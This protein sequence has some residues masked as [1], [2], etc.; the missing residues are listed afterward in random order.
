M[1]QTNISYKQ[2]LLETPFH[3]KT[4]E[5]CYTHD[6]HRWSGYKIAKQYTSA[7]LEYTAIR[8]TA[9]VID[10]TP[11]HKYSVQ[12]KDAKKFINKLITRNVD[13]IQPKQV[14]YALWCNEDGF[15]VDDGT[16]F[17]FDENNFRIC[18]G[19]RNLNW[20]ED[21]AIGFDVIIEDISHSI[22]ALAFQGPL[23][24]KI[25]HML[26]AK[27]IE[28]LKPFCFDQFTINNQE[29]TI[30]RTGFS[31]D[32]GYELWCE[33]SQAHNVWDA[34]FSFNK[35][36]KILAAGLDALEMVRVEAGFI[37]VNADLIAAEHALRPNRMRTPYELGLAWMVNLDKE[38]FSGKE[39]L[40]KQKNKG[41]EK[42]LIGLDVQGDKPAVG[43]VLY[44]ESK[45]KD[46]GIVTAAMW[47]PSLK[48]NIAMGYVD[49]EFMKLGSKVL[50]EIYHPE[51]LEYRKIWA[52]CK[53]VK[54]Q[55]I[56]LE[57]RNA[58]PALI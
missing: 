4:Q 16:I 10:I 15:V 31:G 12:G 11:M 54:K 14:V 29:I 9:G 19:E 44:N 26:N 38:F 6:W 39:A 51:E 34:L 1:S 52:Q 7:E 49:K 28:N 8:N 17:C 46:I 48:S 37:V 24:C 42:K 47:S 2:P 5:R 18:S 58:V 57:R 25:L 21:T 41:V 13:N 36:Y 53:V 20:F 33:P 45:N 40:I 50:A 56:T 55:F 27:N 23:S 32:L 43:S 35:D 3:T 30:S 22:A